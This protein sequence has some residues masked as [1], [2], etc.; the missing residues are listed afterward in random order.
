MRVIL[1]VTSGNEHYSGGCEYAL[2]D[3]TPELAALALRRIA[4]LKEFAKLDP[5]IDETYYWGHCVICYFDPWAG[6]EVED[7]ENTSAGLEDKLDELKIEENGVARVAEDF[8]VAPSQ[9]A[10]VECERMIARA[11]SVAFTA[12]PKHCSFRVETREVPLAMLKAAA[13]TTP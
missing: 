12:I 8:C 10:A 7:R 6:S 5:D 11:D 9:C 3:L 13:S 1:K 4:V 2:L